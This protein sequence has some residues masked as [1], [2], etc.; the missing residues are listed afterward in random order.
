[1]PL[2][3]EL[4]PVAHGQLGVIDIA[5]V[6]VIDVLAPVRRPRHAVGLGFFA[7]LVAIIP[8][9]IPVAS[10][11][12]QGIRD[13]HDHV[14][15]D[16]FI[17][18]RFVH[19]QPIR[20]LHQHL[21]RA[22][23]GAVQPAGE[24]VDRFGLHDDA[25][26]LRL[27]QTARIG[28]PRQIPLVRIQIAYGIFVGHHRDQA[29]ASFVGRARR[30]NLHPLRSGGQ[31]AVIAIQVG[32][33]SQFLRHARVIAQHILGARDADR[34]GQ[35]VHQRAEEF[36]HGGPFFHQ[37]C[38]LLI[39]SLRRRLWLSQRGGRYR[40]SQHCERKQALGFHSS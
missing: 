22:R 29:F 15:P 14:A 25:P 4:Q 16:P 33:P 36:R 37:A 12:L 8:V 17:Q 3:V 40:A 7:Q 6:V 28:Q 21:R 10:I 39:L 5:I 34:L 24:H 30:E 23:F 35:M 27:A 26:G 19:R 1:M 20:Q 2:Q 13:H 9:D 11:R 38:E 32:N 18:R 31:R